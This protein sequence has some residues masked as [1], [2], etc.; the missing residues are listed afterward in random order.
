MRTGLSIALAITLSFSLSGAAQTG[1]PECDD[2]DNCATTP[3]G[4]ACGCIKRLT[5]GLCLE[6]QHGQCAVG[7]CTGPPANLTIP[8]GEVPK[9]VRRLPAEYFNAVA[10]VDAKLAALLKE[11]GFPYGGAGLI[12]GWYV[13]HDVVGATGAGVLYL[14]GTER[15]IA[16]K[17]GKEKTLNTPCAL[18]S[19]AV[20]TTNA[21]K[22]EWKEWRLCSGI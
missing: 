19:G 3:E 5:T 16:V 4:E 6:V 11:E 22:K 17:E 20:T 10:K 18:L 8:G 1:C 15:V 2:Q 14:Y 12:G 21:A 7:A 9:A 13:F